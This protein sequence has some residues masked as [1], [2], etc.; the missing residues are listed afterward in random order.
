ME[1]LVVILIMAILAALLL[2]AISNAKS[3]ATATVCNNHMRQMGQALAM[4]EHDHG[5]KYPYYLGPA[6]SD[7]RRTPIPI[8]IG[9]AFHL[10]A[11]TC[12]D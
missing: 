10:K 11:D 1:L 7:A 3:R 9:Q 6:Y 8:H 2:P 5:S 12:S 4:Y